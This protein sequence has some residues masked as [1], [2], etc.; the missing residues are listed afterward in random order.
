M[1]KALAALAVVP[2]SLVWAGFVYQLVWNWAV[3]PTWHQ[4]H[5]ALAQTMAVSL[6]KTVLTS[7]GETVLYALGFGLIFIALAALVGSFA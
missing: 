7:K 3:S 6:A 2:L 5:V 4:P 1:I